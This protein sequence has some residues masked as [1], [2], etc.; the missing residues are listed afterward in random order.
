MENEAKVQGHLEV[1]DM[2][3]RVHGSMLISHGT[4]SVQCLSY[5]HLNLYGVSSRPNQVF[6]NHSQ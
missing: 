6:G 3:S 2:R 4:P 5:S 1:F